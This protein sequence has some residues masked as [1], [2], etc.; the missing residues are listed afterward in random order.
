MSS[1]FEPTSSHAEY[2]NI[3][4]YF[5]TAISMNFDYITLLFDPLEM[6]RPKS[7]PRELFR[8]FIKLIHPHK[9]FPNMQGL[10][11]AVSPVQKVQIKVFPSFF[12]SLAED[13][14]SFSDIEELQR[15][16]GFPRETM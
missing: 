5:T 8:D 10:L 4:Q 9:G 2:E 7:F 14:L 3:S 1:N 16:I 15:M 11:S 13:K 6:L 12:T